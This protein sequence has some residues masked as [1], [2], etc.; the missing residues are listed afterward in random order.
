MKRLLMVAYHFPPLAG[1]SGIQRTLRF[2]Q[3]LPKFGW[4]PIVLTTIPHAYERTSDDLLN[5]IPKGIV[6][7]RAFALDASRHLSIKGR[8]FAAM[9]CPDRWA[10]W[11]YDAVRKGMKIIKEFKP[12]AIWTTYPIATAHVIG[13]ILHKKSNLPWIADLR[14]PMLQDASP[15]NPLIRKRFQSLEKEIFS[16][17]CRCT[18]TTPSAAKSYQR[19]YPNAAGK[20]AVIENGYDEESFVDVEKSGLPDKGLDSGTI[21]L[22]HSGIVY[23]YERDPTQLFEALSR[24]KAKGKICA[25]KIKI[26]FRAAVHEDFL[27]SLAQKYDIIEFIDCRP[28]I[29][30]RE[31][32]AEMLSAD[33]LLVMQ[34]SSCNEQIPAKIYEYLRAKRPILALTDSIGDTANTLREA[35]VKDIFRLD[36]VSEI[37]AALLG[38]IDAI[39]CNQERL[40]EKAAIEQASREGRTEQ[41]AQILDLT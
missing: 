27:N 38:F 36:S 13:A 24:L 34:A 29:F 31:A 28:P 37:E 2:A 1:S 23:P 35:G 8:Y 7:H 16:L 22:L 15:A 5:D 18:F 10:S 11:K 14:D 39:A 33:G 19:R 40:P 4:D 25:G 20:I 21:T 17:A 9:A 32:L 6:I 12:Q 41:F 26:R 3:H 30:Y